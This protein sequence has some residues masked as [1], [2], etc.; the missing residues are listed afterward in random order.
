MVKSASK[1]QGFG[2]HTHLFVDVRVVLEREAPVGALDLVG[3]R[4][5]RH[6][7]HL[8]RGLPPP[9]GTSVRPHAR[10]S[11]A[12]RGAAAGE[13]RGGARAGGGG[14]SYAD[15]GRRRPRR[16]D[17]A[18]GGGEWQGRTRSGGLQL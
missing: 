14:D 4:R 9:A 8:V 7:E 11:P 13:A 3:R 15:E 1:Q 6:A 10:T 18:A 12:R 2:H 5:R 16:S 17:A